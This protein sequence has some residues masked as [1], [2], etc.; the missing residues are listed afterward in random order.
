MSRGK[1]V[2]IMV[3]G[4]FGF[5]VVAG[6]LMRPFAEG[7]PVRTMIGLAWLAGTVGWCVWVTKRWPLSEPSPTLPRPIPEPV[8]G[9]PFWLAAPGPPPGGVREAKLYQYVLLPAPGLYWVDVRPDHIPD[10]MQGEP[11]AFV[12]SGGALVGGCTPHWLRRYGSRMPLRLLMRVG[13][14]GA[15]VLFPEH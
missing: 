2:W 10:R 9:G 15:T 13:S 4:G 14:E 8:G 1:Q 12:F 5:A 6:T 7:S 11:S 3:G